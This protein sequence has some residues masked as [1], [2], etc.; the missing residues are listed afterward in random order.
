MTS[1]QAGAGTERG[2]LRNEDCGKEKGLRPAPG[3]ESP[4]PACPAMASCYSAWGA[5]GND[6]RL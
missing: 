3:A 5:R 2:A 4:A 6:G 1:G